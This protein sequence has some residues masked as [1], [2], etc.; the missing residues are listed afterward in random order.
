MTLRPVDELRAL[1]ILCREMGV[2]YYLDESV[3]IRFEPSRPAA[4]EVPEA[5]VAT[6][7]KAVERDDGLSTEEAALA[8]GHTGG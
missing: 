3:T 1:M 5:S 6:L 8:Y 2:A 7:P 4:M